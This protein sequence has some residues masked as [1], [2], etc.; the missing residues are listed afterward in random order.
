MFSCVH[1]LLDVILITPEQ[2]V[3]TAPTA[4]A[5]QGKYIAKWDNGSVLSPLTSAVDQ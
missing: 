2:G 5:N 1:L 3:T 4:N